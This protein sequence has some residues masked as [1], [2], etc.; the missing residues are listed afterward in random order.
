MWKGEYCS[1]DVAVKVLR[2]HLNSDIQRIIGVSC[3]SRSLTV[4]LYTDTTLFAEVLQGGHDMENPPTSEYPTVDWSHDVRNPVRNGVR[5]DG[6]WEHQPIC[7]ETPGCKPVGI[8]RIVHSDLESHHL[9]FKS[10]DG[11]MAYPAGRYHE[12]IDLYSQPGNDPWRS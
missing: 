7:E 5:V 12:R 1:R 4:C 3:R 6:E 2:T 10:T 8:G 9:R 11:R